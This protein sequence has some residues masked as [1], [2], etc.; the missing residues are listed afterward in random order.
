M[1]ITATDRSRK[2]VNPDE[3]K[4]DLELFKEKH[5]DEKDPKV[6]HV[7]T[8]RVDNYPIYSLPALEKFGMKYSST[9]QCMYW[10]NR[11]TDDGNIASVFDDMLLSAT[12]N[13][14]KV[15]ESQ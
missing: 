8:I 2:T 6:F 15:K 7:F 3:I 11:L 9:H 10:H 14:F 5:K 1:N 4:Q 12:L 13:H